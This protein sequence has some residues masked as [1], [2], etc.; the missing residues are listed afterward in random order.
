MFV[1]DQNPNIRHHDLSISFVPKMWESRPECYSGN[2]RMGR[3]CKSSASDIEHS[4][5]VNHAT[6]G[7]HD[8]L[9]SVK[10]SSKRPLP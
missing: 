5:F 7:D 9:A 8:A 1:G 10:R 3:R 4:L 6:L 2:V